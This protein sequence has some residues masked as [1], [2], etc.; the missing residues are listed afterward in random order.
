M[1]RIGTC[2]ECNFWMEGGLNGQEFGQCI[3][4]APRVVW[5]KPADEVQASDIWPTTFADWGCG[6]WEQGKK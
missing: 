5:T 6:E 3:R 4:H 1:T 2:G